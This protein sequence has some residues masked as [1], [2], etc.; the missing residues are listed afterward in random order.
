MAL[1]STAKEL[2][3]GMASA[4]RRYAEWLVSITWKRF[5][6]LSIL[7]LIIAAG[8]HH[9]LLVIVHLHVDGRMHLKLKLALGPFE[10]QE[11]ILLG[12]FHAAR[13]G[14]GFFSYSAHNT[15]VR[16]PSSVVRCN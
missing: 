4:Y 2:G 5:I 1:S 7:L 3:A 6:V 11:M 8:D 16:C 13:N 10:L 15:P 9:F 12:D 14:D